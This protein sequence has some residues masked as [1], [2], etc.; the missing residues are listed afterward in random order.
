MCTFYVYYQREPDTGLRS[1]K[2]KTA[3]CAL[4]RDNISKIL[5]ADPEGFPLPLHLN[6]ILPSPLLISGRYC[7]VLRLADCPQYYCGEIRQMLTF[8]IDFYCPE[9]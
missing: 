9:V 7:L 4:T 2:T 6:I 5:L 8:F 1:F 3:S